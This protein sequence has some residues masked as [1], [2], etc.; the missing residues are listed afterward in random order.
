MEYDDTHLLQTELASP[1]PQPL[2]PHPFRP[3]SFPFSCR[4]ALFLSCE[5][6]LF[7]S[8]ACRSAGLRE[9]LGLTTIAAVL[10]PPTVPTFLRLL[11]QRPP[12]KW[13][14]ETS[15]TRREKR[16]RR[17]SKYSCLCSLSLLLSR[18]VE[19][20]EADSS[21]GLVDLLRRAAEGKKLTGNPQQRNEA[22]AAAL[23]A[24]IE[25]RFVLPYLQALRI[26]GRRGTLTLPRARP[27]TPQAKKA[28]AALAADP[29]APQPKGGFQ[30]QPKK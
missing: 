10:P 3:F 5:L 16:T 24:K 4:S 29:N 19:R 13:L 8:A 18:R 6:L 9:R 2:Y 30:K 28:A 20:I 21:F 14:V 23:A 27:T 7:C 17:P 1:F 15:V 11:H 26:I 25:V 12:S 22:N